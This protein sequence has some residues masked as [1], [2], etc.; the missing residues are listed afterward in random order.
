M[1]NG[2][3]KS[4]TKL[5]DSDIIL[6]DNEKRIIENLRKQAESNPHSQLAV[7][8]QVHNGLVQYGTLCLGVAPNCSKIRL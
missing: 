1:V 8:F 7:L 5:S 6:T 2:E 4:L 3:N